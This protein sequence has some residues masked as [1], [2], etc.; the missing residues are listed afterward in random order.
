MKTKTKKFLSH[1]NAILVGI[2]DGGQSKQKRFDLFSRKIF[3]LVHIETYGSGV[4]AA[5]F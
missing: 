4:W 3:L 2:L 5:V 1:F